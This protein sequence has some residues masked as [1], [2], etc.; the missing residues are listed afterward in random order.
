MNFQS[1]FKGS[2]NTVDFVFELAWAEVWAGQY[3]I[4]IK[5]GF[6]N[7]PKVE[8]S[9]SGLINVGSSLQDAHKAQFW[10]EKLTK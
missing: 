8:N 5:I 4:K 3:L 2:K 7:H 9:L 1:I 6:E 10:H